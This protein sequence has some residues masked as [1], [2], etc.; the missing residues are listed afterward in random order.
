MP[1]NEAK[2]ERK[3]VKVVEIGERKPFGDRGAS[4]LDFKVL[5]AGEGDK[6]L[7]FQA[8]NNSFDEHIKKDA[9]FEL[10]WETKVRETADGST[11][12]NRKV[13]QIYID[14]QPV[15]GKEQYR[16]YSRGD[17]SP[18]KRASIESQMAA[19]I[20]KDLIISEFFTTDDEEVKDLRKWLRAKLNHGRPDKVEQKPP[21]IEKAEVVSSQ[22]IKE[23]KPE[24]I[25]ASED[26]D[27]LGREPEPPPENISDLEKQIEYLQGKKITGYSS[28]TLVSYLGNLGGEGKTWQEKLKNLAPD[29]LSEFS[30]MVDKKVRDIEGL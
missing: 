27:N 30:A 11:F 4:K 1:D 17:D 14:G 3:K 5:V 6:P 21:K 16:G 9:V 13:I 22:P 23:E 2:T 12:T 26:F 28:T 7:T 8:L 20:V 18:E 19:N 24:P 25:T 29:K 10:E 15:K